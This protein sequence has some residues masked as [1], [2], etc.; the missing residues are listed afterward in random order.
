MVERDGPS[1]PGVGQHDPLVLGYEVQIDRLVE[2][3]SAGNEQVAG[4]GRR[5]DVSQNLLK[6]GAGPV[7][8]AYQV[9]ADAVGYAGQGDELASGFVAA[10]YVVEVHRHRV[11]DEAGD[12][13]VPRVA[14]NHRR[15]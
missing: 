15:L 12:R 3:V 11:I 13:Q 10:H 5:L 8:R 14:V 6:A 1:V 2:P 9:A 4:F 7:G